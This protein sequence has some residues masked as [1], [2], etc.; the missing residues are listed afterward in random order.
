M[1]MLVQIAMRGTSLNGEMEAEVQTRVKAVIVALAAR[2]RRRLEIGYERPTYGQPPVQVCRLY[3]RGCVH[4][5][6]L[7]IAIVAVDAEIVI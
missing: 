4:T 3:N 2:P 6:N 5:Q 7:G 1:G